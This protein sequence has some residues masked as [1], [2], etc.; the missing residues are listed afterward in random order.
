MRGADLQQNGRRPIPTQATRRPLRAKYF[1]CGMCVAAAC[2]I[3]ESV[4]LEPGKY[5]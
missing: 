3:V 4:S 1:G 2:C 5:E